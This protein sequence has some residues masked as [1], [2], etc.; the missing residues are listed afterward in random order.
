LRLSVTLMYVYQYKLTHVQS[1][2]F[3]QLVPKDPFLQPYAFTVALATYLHSISLH[4]QPHRHTPQFLIRAHTTPLLPPQISPTSSSSSASTR[5]HLTTAHLTRALLD[6]IAS[7]YEKARLSDPKRVRRV[8]L[9]RF[10]L[11]AGPASDGE[12]DVSDGLGPRDAST[13]LLG[14]IGSLALG[15]GDGPGNVLDVVLDLGVLA[16]A[17]VGRGDRAETKERKGNK[18]KD[19]EIWEGG[20]E[21][22]RVGASLKGL[23]SGNVASVLRMRERER[24]RESMGAIVKGKKSKGGRKADRDKDRWALSDGDV[25]DVAQ[26]RERTE[27]KS[28]EDESEALSAFT[29]IG[30]GRPWSGKVQKKLELWTG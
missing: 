19:V 4:A 5:P 8:L 15:R 23:W 27:G 12:I 21:K 18:D 10:D 17:V 14:G 22:D 16:R 1:N 11:R 2:S 26:E 6:T 3:P 28:T 29:G 20:K 30:M 13:P 25:D 24:A 9:N 7:A